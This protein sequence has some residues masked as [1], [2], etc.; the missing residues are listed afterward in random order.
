[1]KKQKSY[2]EIIGETIEQMR[3]EKGWTQEEL[4]KAVGT[5]QSA[6]HRIVIKITNQRL[7][8]Y[9]RLQ[10]TALRGVWAVPRSAVVPSALI[11]SEYSRSRNY[12]SL[13]EPASEA[14]PEGSEMPRMATATAVIPVTG[15][16]AT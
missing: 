9:A 2:Q 4:A 12:D 15:F 6:I 13:S 3:V 5:S 14:L 1:M 7:M 10:I 16:W 8:G 11:L